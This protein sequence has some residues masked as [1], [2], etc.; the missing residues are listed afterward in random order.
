MERNPIKLESM[1][2]NGNNLVIVNL[3]EVSESIGVWIYVKAK[4]GNWH[5]RC[6]TSYQ[7]E[8]LWVNDTYCTLLINYNYKKV[9][10][11]IQMYKSKR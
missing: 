1:M 6:R 10:I 2:D 9:L 3:Y 7:R 4:E 8:G 5:Q 11:S